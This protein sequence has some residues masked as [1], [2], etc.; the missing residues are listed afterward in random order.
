MIRTH[1]SAIYILSLLMLAVVTGCSTA[2]KATTPSVSNGGIQNAESYFRQIMTDNG[3]WNQIK[4]PF[5]V[6]ITQPTQ[7]SASGQATMVRGRYINLSMRVLG[8]EVAALYI[9]NDS[10]LVVDRWNKRYISENLRQFLKGFPANISNLQDLLTGH[11]FIIGDESL[12]NSSFKQLAIEQQGAI[13]GAKPY[14]QAQ[15]AE[16]AFTFNGT[17]L[18]QL[19]VFTLNE[20]KATATY[21]VPSKTSVGNFADYIKLQSDAAKKPI[22]AS[23]QWRWN[24]AEFNNSFTAKHIELPTGYT[25][26]N[27]ADLLSKLKM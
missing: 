7:L 4:V 5:N 21:G 8:M 13:W 19:V 27:A 3:E 22:S 9:T 15:N 6:S 25:K 11:P 2:K 20:I 18:T 24:K 26:I 10:V 23:I 1:F 17:Q 12:N 14:T 16:Y